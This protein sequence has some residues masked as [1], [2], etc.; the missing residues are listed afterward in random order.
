MKDL[1]KRMDNNTKVEELDHTN[2]VKQ[3]AW[4]DDSE[5]RMN[6]KEMLKPMLYGIAIAGC[7]SFN[8]IDSPGRKSSNKSNSTLKSVLSKYYR[9]IFFLLIVL[10]LGKFLVAFFYLPSEAISFNGLCFAWTIY[11]LCLF[12]INIKATNSKYGH[13][14]GVFKFW[15]ETIA[16]EFKELGIDYPASKTRKCATL[17]LVISV[18]IVIS[19]V[20]GIGVQV[21]FSSGDMYTS[22]FESNPLTLTAF[23][24]LI[25]ASTCVWILPVAYVI[26]VSKL[27]Q[28][29]FDCLSNHGSTVCKL[30]ACKMPD[31]FQKIRLLHMNLSRLVQDIDK[32]LSWF[33][34]ASFTFNIG[35]SVF[36]LYQIM[37]T[38]RDRFQLVLF[39]S[40]FLSGL[41]SMGLMSSYAAFVHEAVSK[42]D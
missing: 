4:T 23:F 20:A 26:M 36:T 24:I 33:Y 25:T 17:I 21:V 11:V 13:Y 19:N 30:H 31:N 2:D 9:F 5:D 28:E 32:D 41:A 39:L 10:S 7:Y 35:L 16:V 22:P 42:P 18:I 3:N 40:W 38:T 37:N 1:T 8:D 27:L 15:E 34:A 12:L 6:M 29:A 14:E